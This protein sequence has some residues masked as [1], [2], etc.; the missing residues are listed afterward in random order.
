MQCV[1]SIYIW[2]ANSFGY[3]LGS[4]KFIKMQLRQN[5]CQSVYI[6][7]LNKHLLVYRV[8]DVSL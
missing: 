3:T 1:D 7:F 4:P 2:Y 6:K 8:L 5:Q